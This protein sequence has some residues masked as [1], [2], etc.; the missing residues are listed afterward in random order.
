MPWDNPDIYTKWS[1]S[2]YEKDFA[3][4]TLVIHGELDFRIPYSQGLQL[5]TVL[6]MRKIPSQLLIF[7][8]EGHWILKP[9][10]SLLWYKT[11]LDWVGNWTKK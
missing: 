10:N 6:Q 8:D 7:P 3:T 2:S 1:P 4:P 9:A 11:F 5:Y